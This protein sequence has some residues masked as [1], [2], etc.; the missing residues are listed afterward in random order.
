MYITDPSIRRLR[1]S[2]LSFRSQTATDLAFG[3]MRPSG[4]RIWFLTFIFCYIPFLFVQA[5]IPRGFAKHNGI[6][7]RDALSD[8]GLTSASWIWTSDATVG[9]V[10]FLKTFN[11]AAGKTALSATISMTAVNQFTLWVNGQPIG[12]SGDG[13]DDWK[14]AQMFSAALNASTNTLSVLA[15]NK[16]NAG[17]P[18]PGFLAAIQVKYSDGSGETVVSD[19]SWG[20]SAFI[21]SDFPTPSDT[22][23]FASAASAAPFGSGVWGSSVTIASADPNTPTLSAS[24]WIWS[25]SNAASTAAVG[26]VGFR[27]TVASPSGKSATSALIVITVDNGFS[28]Y[29]NGKYVGAPPNAPSIPDFRRPQQFRVALD[30]ASNIFTVFGQN[31]PD[32]GSTDAGPAGVLAAIR[33]QYS[34]GSSD[35]VGTDASWLSGA[36][37]SVPTFLSTADT[38]LSPAF[39]I[40]ALGAEPWGALSSVSNA[41]AAADVPVGPFASGTAAQVSTTSSTGG[42][43]TAA[44]TISTTPVSATSTSARASTSVATASLAGAASAPSFGDL[45]APT[46]TLGTANSA[47]SSSDP[48]APTLSTALIALLVVGVLALVVVGVGLFLWRRRRAPA[49][50]QRIQST[51]LFAAANDPRASRGGGGSEAGASSRRTSFTTTTSE[52]IIRRAE[53]AWLQPQRATSFTYPHAPVYQQQPPH[54][55]PPPMAYA[56]GAAQPVTQSA[57]IPPTKFEREHAIWQRNAAEATAGNT[58]VSAATDGVPTTTSDSAAPTPDA[59]LSTAQTHISSRASSVLSVAAAVADD[60]DAYGGLETPGIAPPSYYA[61]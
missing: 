21:P 6:G 56:D 23:P 58:S 11:S 42:A 32:P 40:G 43:S 27:K 45:A 18:A 25:T 29:V 51:Q 36:F 7:K 61:Q 10:A 22:S 31:I 57:I 8:S 52:A 3:S 24:S 4:S 47:A 14:S 35:L 30:A 1:P 26:T 17:G 37:T 38:A 2:P 5:H 50:H 16:A 19:S 46:S 49:R 15:A 28:L 9:N 39:A 44:Q 20:V 33:I 13:P 60:D 34:D 12:A 55:Q 41:L 48:S 54:P 53:M 59:R